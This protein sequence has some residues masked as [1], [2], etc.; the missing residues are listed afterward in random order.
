MIKVYWAAPL[1]NVGERWFNRTMRAELMRWEHTISVWLPQS[2]AIDFDKDGWQQDVF[3]EN[4]RHINESDVMCAV[5]DGCLVDDGT[6]WE[7]GYAY[8]VNKPIIGIKTDMRNVG[9]DGH[10]NLMLER[11]CAEIVGGAGV[12]VDMD[13]MYSRITEAILRAQV[14]Q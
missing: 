4:V 8:S 1:F 10:V 14:N 11:A 6:A 9:A 3:D 5:L 2:L 13:D 12:P 7:I